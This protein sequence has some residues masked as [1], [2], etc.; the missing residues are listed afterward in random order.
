MKKLH[1]PGHSVLQHS[2]TKVHT[3]GTM[4]AERWKLIPSVWI[5]IGQVFFIVILRCNMTLTSSVCPC[6]PTANSSC[7]MSPTTTT[8]SN[9]WG[10]QS[11]GKIK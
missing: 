9:S 4:G 1:S 5:I 6:R 3:N 11:Y 10:K 8:S 7:A 2:S